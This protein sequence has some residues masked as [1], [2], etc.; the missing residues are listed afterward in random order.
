MFFGAAGFYR[1]IMFSRQK[2]HPMGLDRSAAFASSL[3]AIVLRALFGRAGVDDLFR[4]E[5]LSIALNGTEA[6]PAREYFIVLAT[7]L[8]R[9]PLGLM[10]FWGEGPGRCRYTYIESPTRW[11]RA[12]LLPVLR[13]R[14]R[15]WMATNGYVSGRADQIDLRMNSPIVF[16]GQIFMPRPDH[17]V[18]LR[19]DHEAVFVRC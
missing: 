3:T 16:D 14:P 5:R 7:T 12:A 11:L 8:S 6:A 9:L 10:P 4:G 13:G 17:P 2:I 15:P 1:A 19:V 18:T